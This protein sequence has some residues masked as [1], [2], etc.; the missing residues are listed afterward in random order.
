[1]L[2]HSKASVLS[3]LMI[4]RRHHSR[5]CSISDVKARCLVVLFGCWCV[6]W[7]IVLTGSSEFWDPP[8]GTCRRGGPSI[9]GEGGK[10]F[11]NTVRHFWKGGGVIWG[12]HTTS[13]DSSWTKQ[14]SH[15]LTIE[16]TWPATGEQRSKRNKSRCFMCVCGGNLKV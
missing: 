3:Y 16:M 15:V 4:I 10:L 2:K 1:M 8:N 7:L 13:W 6:L 9:C 14:L 5:F 12:L 11:N